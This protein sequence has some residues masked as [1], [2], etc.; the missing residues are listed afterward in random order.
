[1]HINL[2]CNAVCDW[3]MWSIKDSVAEKHQS[4]HNIEY[5]IWAD[6]AIMQLPFV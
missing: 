5:N 2:K 1:M 3:V 4:E 6:I